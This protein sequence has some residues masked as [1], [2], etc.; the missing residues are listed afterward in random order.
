M[1]RFLACAHPPLTP[2]E[3]GRGGADGCAQ[4]SDFWTNLKS[5]DGKEQQQQEQLQEQEQ[6]SSPFSLYIILVL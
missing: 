5:R 2:K 1:F 3:S 6:K 4:A